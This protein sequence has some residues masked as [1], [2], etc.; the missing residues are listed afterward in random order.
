M[1]SKDDLGQF[2]QFCGSLIPAFSRISQVECVQGRAKT[3]PTSAQLYRQ[4]TD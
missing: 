1:S 4:T 3:I 2:V